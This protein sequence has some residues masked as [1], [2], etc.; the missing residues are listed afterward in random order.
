M[1]DKQVKVEIVTPERIVFSEDVEFVVVPGEEG[2]LGILANHAPIVAALKIGVM[3]VIQNQ[4][5]IKLAISGGF[6]EV[7][8]NK[9]VV[10][11]DTAERGDE[12]DVARARAAKERAEQRLA[13]RTHDID[14][15]RAELALRRA[16]ARIKAAGHDV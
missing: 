6:M 10:L 4:K 8:K 14:L 12:I 3:K 1:A 15:V 7:S 16:I 13:S 2:Y 11:A 5:E 9:L